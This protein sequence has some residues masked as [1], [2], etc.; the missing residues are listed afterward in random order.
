M[1]RAGNPAM[2]PFVHPQR[3]DALSPSAQAR[4]R[5]MTLQGTINAS[6]V[7]L[8]LC[9]ISALAS[10]T[11]ARDFIMP[12]T[13]GGMIG[14]LVLALIIAFVPR[15]A[16]VLG[17]IYAIVEGCFLG[18]VSLFYASWAQ[19][20]VAAESD[21]IV[22]SISDSIV[23]QS[24]MLTF[25]VAGTMLLA[26]SLRVIRATPMLIKGIVMLT[27]AVVLVSLSTFVLRF[28]IDIPYLHQ[29]GGI[30]IAIA[31]GV[32]VLAAFNLILDFHVIEEGVKQGAPK[33]MEWY[34]AFALTVTLV[35]LYLRI[36][37]LLAM[38]R[39]ND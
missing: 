8:G 6:A 3:Y 37:Y 2:Q 33:Y 39:R 20:Q 19:G 25:G 28:F 15:M 22:T 16:P 27:G 18:G 34:G 5:A 13:F 11:F 10:V 21:S 14:G 36:L 30:G 32:I 38:L 23:L 12:L 35:W 24:V 26:Y 1:L 29:M 17:P 31:V 7:L 9:A 4:P